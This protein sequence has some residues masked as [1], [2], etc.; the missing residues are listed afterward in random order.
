MELSK[1]NFCTQMHEL[2]FLIY[3]L[4]KVHSGN[5][6]FSRRPVNRSLFFM[7]FQHRKGNV[8]TAK[9]WAIFHPACSSKC[10]FKRYG[11]SSPI[12]RLEKWTQHLPWKK[13][14]KKNTDCKWQFAIFFCTFKTRK[15]HQKVDRIS[16]K[17]STQ[18]GSY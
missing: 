6:F 1:K 15:L 2:H 17:K 3:M 8:L 4:L 14:H 9:K 16:P 18:V 12:C 11:K 10:L 13:K 5:V 7:S